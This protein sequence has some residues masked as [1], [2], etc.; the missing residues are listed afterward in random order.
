MGVSRIRLA[1]LTTLLLLPF[2]DAGRVHTAASTYFVSASGSD[3]NDG[4]ASSPF[5]T[6]NRALQLLAPGG[7]LYIRGGSYGGMYVGDPLLKV[8]AGTSWSSPITIAAYPGEQPVLTN[9][10]VGAAGAQYLIFSG[11]TIDTRGAVNEGIWVGNGAHHIRFQNMEVRNAL[12]FGVN[13]SESSG[14]YNEFINLDVHHSGT[15]DH[16]HGLYISS[17]GNVIDGCRIHDNGAYGVHVYAGTP[18]DNTVRNNFIYDNNRAGGVSAGIL[19][20]G[21]RNTAYNNVIFRNGT[22]IQ[23]AY[24]SPAN[25]GVYNNTIYGN[26]EQ[27]IFVQQGNGAIVRNNIVYKNA[28]DI[29]NTGSSTTLSNNFTADPRFVNAPSDFSLQQGSPA[30]DAGASISVVGTDVRGMSRPQGSAMDI[31]AYEYAQSSSSSSS[32][33]TTSGS[34]TTTTTTDST[35]TTTSKKGPKSPKNVRFRS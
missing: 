27:G 2:H 24:T 22:G 4:S 13:V 11:I 29:Q 21:A 33:T 7:S 26:T 9:I 14:G 28:S 31:G 3:T 10:G 20:G 17:R 19:L 23:I 15:T 16:D 18:D 12:H 6:F 34:T 35:T 1:A 25:N 30:I 32:T 5:R 8:P